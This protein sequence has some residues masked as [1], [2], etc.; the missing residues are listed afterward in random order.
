M[1]RFMGYSQ[2][3]QMLALCITV[4][5]MFLGVRSELSQDIKGCQEAMSDLYSCLPFVSNK[6]KAPDS[7]CCS[8]LKAKIDKGQTKKCLCTLVKDRDDPGLGFKVDGNRAM[9]LPSACHVPANIS[10]CPDLL[11]LLPDSPASQ[12]F[13]QFNESS[14]Q[15]VGHKAVSTSSSSKGRDKRQFGLMLAGVLSVWYLV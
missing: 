6:A 13:K 8:T 2:N 12:I 15:N 11:H 5:V 10:Q 1:A 14:S 4:A 3:R 7:T 9:S